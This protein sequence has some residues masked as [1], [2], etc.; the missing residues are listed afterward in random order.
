MALDVIIRHN[1]SV[2]KP[3]LCY[4]VTEEAQST[5]VFFINDPNDIKYATD[6]SN[7]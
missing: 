3:F 4:G 5:C 2:R 6:K 7:Y 1:I